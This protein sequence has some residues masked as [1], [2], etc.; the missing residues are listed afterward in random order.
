MTSGMD[1]PELNIKGVFFSLFLT[2]P[3][4]LIV[5]NSRRL[6]SK[7]YSVIVFKIYSKQAE[8]FGE[9]SDNWTSDDH[10]RL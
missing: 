2:G 5:W 8:Y 4:R 6:E 1:E 10:V 9:V 3:E 7:I